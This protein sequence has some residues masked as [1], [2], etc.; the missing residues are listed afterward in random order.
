MDS[1]RAKVKLRPE[2]VKAIGKGVKA[3]NSGDTEGCSR[4]YRELCVRHR[5][6]D[7]RLE[8]ALTLAGSPGLDP[9]SGWY[10]RAALDSILEGEDPPSDAAALGGM[11]GQRAFSARLCLNIF[12][13][14]ANH[15]KSFCAVI[16]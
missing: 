10:Y 8:H 14:K 6:Q 15:R 12:A 1:S 4:V 11:E 3:W 5:E 13:R 2:I 7:V 9:S 16:C